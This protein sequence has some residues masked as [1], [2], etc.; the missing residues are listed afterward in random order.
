MRAEDRAFPRPV[1]V[2]KQDMP[3]RRMYDLL[4][5]D[6]MLVDCLR[7]LEVH[8]GTVDVSTW[9]RVSFCVG[10]RRHL[11][12]RYKRSNIYISFRY[13]YTYQYTCTHTYD[14]SVFASVH[15]GP[16]SVHYSSKNT[17]IPPENLT[18]FTNS[19]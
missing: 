15:H 7:S 13:L 5:K 3:A 4:V 11:S 16:G 10:L 2:G 18:L 19:P 12:I 8:I 9:W 6:S 14:E 1:P 17:D